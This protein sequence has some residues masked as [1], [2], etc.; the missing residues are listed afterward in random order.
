MLLGQRS[1]AKAQRILALL[2]LAGLIASRI[3]PR[4]LG[5]PLRRAYFARAYG[6]FADRLWPQY[7]QFLAGVRAHTQ[8]GDSIAIVV[9][10][11]EW[12]SGYSYAYYRASYL[13][14]GREVLPLADREN[15]LQLL[16]FRQAKYIA[17]WNTAMP[18]AHFTTVW[19]GAGGVLLRH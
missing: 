4:L 7:P 13:L 17:V 11:L 2:V 16:N 18:Q 10:T 15:H 8:P 12:D 19:R 3:E 9:P 6:A 14:T 1:T 5:V